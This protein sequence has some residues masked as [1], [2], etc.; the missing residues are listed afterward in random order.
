MQNRTT[1]HIHRFRSELLSDFSVALFLGVSARANSG[2]TDQH[3]ESH[4]EEVL[5]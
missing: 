3:F 2:S 1:S 4:H 5:S